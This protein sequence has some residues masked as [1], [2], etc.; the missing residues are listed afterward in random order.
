M[1]ILVKN[2]KKLVVSLMLIQILFCY[3]VPAFAEAHITYVPDSLRAKQVVDEEALLKRFESNNTPFNEILNAKN[4]LGGTV[5]II[6]FAALLSK[7]KHP[8]IQVENAESWDL[9]YTNQ[10]ILDGHLVEKEF[11]NLEQPMTR[12]NAARILNRYVETNEK[13]TYDAL[14]KSYVRRILNDVKYDVFGPFANL[15]YGLYTHKDFESISKMH[16]L[17]IMDCRTEGVFHPNRTITKAEVVTILQRLVYKE[18]RRKPVFDTSSKDMQKITFNKNSIVEC[19]R[20]YDLKTKTDVFKYQ[21][22][23]WSLM[24][25][26][27]KQEFYLMNNLFKNNGIEPIL[28]ESSGDCMA[29][30]DLGLELLYAIDDKGRWYEAE[31]SHG[32]LRSFMFFNYNVGKVK[33]KNFV[34]ELQTY[35]P[36]V[37]TLIVVPVNYVLTL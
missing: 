15:S 18:L 32:S 22:A 7:L 26:D 17:G 19:Q 20:V 4:D 27:K 8:E 16:L 11:R 23:T 3:T 29:F 1:R 25:P 5:S 12:A 2:N 21:K 31:D 28:T 9:I 24:A 30:E 13:P 37:Q 10:A 33:V 34:F 36:K 35:D 14:N 6:E